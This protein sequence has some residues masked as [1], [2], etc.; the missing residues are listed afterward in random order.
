[1]AAC[2]T[3]APLCR[4]PLRHPDVLGVPRR[5]TAHRHGAPTCVRTNVPCWR[6]DTRWLALGM[7]AARYSIQR[8]HYC[9]PFAVRRVTVAQHW[10]ATNAPP[11]ALVTSSSAKKGAMGL[12]HSFSPNFVQQHPHTTV[13]TFLRAPLSAF[14]QL[15]IS[16]ITPVWWHPRP[17]QHSTS[18]DEQ[19]LQ[20]AEEHCGRLGPICGDRKGAQQTSSWSYLLEQNCVTV[21]RHATW[22]WFILRQ[23]VADSDGRA[24]FDNCGQPCPAGA[25]RHGGRTV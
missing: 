16:S 7:P 25:G 9:I 10:A 15:P 1:M 4:P 6:G 24:T 2:L 20:V 5:H 8:C 23:P 13:K 12:R 22:T 14:S 19:G 11:P 18:E 17:R 3:D 21:S